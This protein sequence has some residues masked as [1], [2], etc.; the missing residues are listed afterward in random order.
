MKLTQTAKLAIDAYGGIELWKSHKYIEAEVSVKGLAFT[1]KRR[2]FFEKAKIKMEIAR[3]FSVIT[4]IGKEKLIS[5]VLDGTDV[6]LQ[7]SNGNIIEERKDA[8]T[9][10]PNGRR[11]FYWDDLDMAYFA[12]YA[13]WNYFTFPFLLTNTMIQWTEKEIGVLTAEFPDSIPTHSRN[14]EFFFDNKTGL[15]K[16]HNYTVDII[17]KLAK[18]ANAILE[19]KT[20]ENVVFPSV[21]LVTPQD[22][23]GNALSIPTLIDIRIHNFVLSNC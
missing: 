7:D 6:G 1:I 2:P 23:K 12:N 8:R 3:P 20:S 17:S 13:F 15:L 9:Y 18:A 10:F 5:G 14:Q 22:R 4:P 19:H 16:Q 21:R 11:L